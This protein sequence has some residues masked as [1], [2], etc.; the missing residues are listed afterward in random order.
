MITGKA[1]SGS[2]NA[3]PSLWNQGSHANG[4]A[5]IP[6]PH[7]ADGEPASQQRVF[8]REFLVVGVQIG[9]APENG[10]FCQLSLQEILWGLPYKR[11]YELK[12][13]R[14]RKLIEENK[15]LERMAQEKQST[16]IRNEILRPQY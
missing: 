14:E 6:A 2:Q 11:L 10:L 4:H 7:S 1:P 8:Q 15:D 3:V 9:A 12:E 5:H 13:S 16:A